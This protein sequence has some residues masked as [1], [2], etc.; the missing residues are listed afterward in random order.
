MNPY[1]TKLSSGQTIES[2]IEKESKKES[3]KYFQEALSDFIYD[4]ASGRAI[5]H[6]ADAGYTSAQI[7]RH[8]A[9][10]VPIEKIRKTVTRHLSETGILLSDLPVSPDQ[11]QKIPINRISEQTLFSQLTDC[12]LPNG[13]E[14]SYISCP[15][16]T[17]QEKQADQILQALSALTS[18]ETEYISGIEWPSKTIYHRLNRR[19]LEIGVTLAMNSDVFS[20]YFITTNVILYVM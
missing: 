9:Y 19:M 8:L 12:L 5:R 15:F 4:A 11:M 14:H 20:F 7:S 18:R 3:K 1:F 10:P 17:T 6:L 13:E 16:G 2:G